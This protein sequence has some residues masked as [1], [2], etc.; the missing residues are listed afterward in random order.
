MVSLTSCRSCQAVDFAAVFMRFCASRLLRK[1]ERDA[2]QG[3]SE[4][5]PALNQTLR[6]LRAADRSE[7]SE[8]RSS[9]YAEADEGVLPATP[10]Y[11]LSPN[12]GSCLSTVRF[13]KQSWTPFD[14]GADLEYNSSRT[15]QKLMPDLQKQTL[16]Q[17]ELSLRPHSLQNA[18][19][20]GYQDRGQSA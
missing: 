13:T 12:F 4:L 7:G 5:R 3:V 15:S 20:Q 6:S 16:A 9:M 19:L 17:R 2:K 18:L 14:F 1:L 10:D 11:T 8:P